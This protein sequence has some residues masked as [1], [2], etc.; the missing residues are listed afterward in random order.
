MANL[1]VK[2]IVPIAKL[3]SK[4]SPHSA[5]LDISACF[6]EST[7]TIYDDGLAPERTASKDI[8]FRLISRAKLNNDYPFEEISEMLKIHKTEGLESYLMGVEFTDE[9]FDTIK[10]SLDELEKE[11]VERK[12]IDNKLVI[13]PGE[14]VMIPTGLTMSCD[15]NH[16]LAFY[17]RSGNA[18]K[19]G[20]TLINCTG[21]GDR[22]YK[23]EYYITLV[24]NSRQT[25]VIQN[26]E[27]CAQMIV[28]Y[29]ADVDICERPNGLPEVESN[30]DGG[31]GS[32]GK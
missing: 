27:R 25:A 23:N 16:Y 13:Y 19:R 20:L 17:P 12:I 24:N 31:F 26:G 2:R 11:F 3:P 1:F 30:R 28:R 22:D 21:I 6:H 9:E 32:S 7:V 14:R 4:A 29:Y 18:L 8:I 10:T 15:A 5:G